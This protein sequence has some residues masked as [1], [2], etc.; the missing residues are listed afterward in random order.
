MSQP[1]E[2][3]KWWRVGLRWIGMLGL[4]TAV[5]SGIGTLAYF[6]WWF[7]Q[8]TG[9]SQPP[10]N[11][12]G[13][14]ISQGK[15]LWDWLDLLLVPAVLAVG[16]A[17]LTIAE[18]RAAQRFQDQREQETRR[19]EEQRFQD[20]VLQSYLDMMSH[21]LIEKNLH[22]SHPADVVSIAARARTLAVLSVV[23]GV[24]KGAVVK[25]LYEAQL[26]GS[27]YVGPPDFIE[28]F[29]RPV[30]YLSGA[31]LTKAMLN[32]TVL[33]GAA[34]MGTNLAGANL[35]GSNLSQA[36]LV[37]TSLSDANLERTTLI[38]AILDRTNLSN[39]NLSGADLSEASLIQA[40][41]R[42]TYLLTA[43]I[44]ETRLLGANLS[45][46]KISVR[47]LAFAATI[48]TATLPAH[49]TQHDIEAYRQKL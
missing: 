46:A 2:R 39:A 15:T 20:T 27:V 49:I 36:S 1:E 41:L 24:R 38:C 47:Q 48:E 25:F 7:P 26:I 4:V 23:D 43:K 34:L 42:G 14:A 33:S 9:F 21:L 28:N 17:I 22:G 32:N 13:E 8:W 35:E 44:A 6:S 16:G 11:A 31:D 40:D 12:Q 30:I 10:L 45:T 19:L 37:D 3:P 5:I 29:V 18:S